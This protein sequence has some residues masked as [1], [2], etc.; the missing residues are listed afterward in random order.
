[1]RG[2]INALGMG[3]RGE[4]GAAAGEYA[5]YLMRGGQLARAG[6]GS[7][8]GKGAMIGAGIGAAYGAVSDDTSMLGGAAMGAG[9]GAVG[10]RY[11]GAGRAW[12]GAARGG[13][14]SGYS[15]GIMSQARKDIRGAS[16]WLGMSPELGSNKGVSSSVAMGS[17]LASAARAPTIRSNRGSGG[18]LLSRR[19]SQERMRSMRQGSGE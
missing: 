16:R 13:T 14:F 3:L 12:A 2:L 1:M 6:W 19:L 8:M 9:L 11:L 18:S 7:R 4:A 17:S 5:G 10:G 15:R